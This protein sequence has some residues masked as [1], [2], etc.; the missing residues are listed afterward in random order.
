MNITKALPSRYAYSNQKTETISSQQTVQADTFRSTQGMEKPP[1]RA[2]LKAFFEPKPEPPK[3]SPGELKMSR[4]PDIPSPARSSFGVAEMGTKVYI[5]GGHQGQE[6]TY[7][8]ESFMDQFLVFDKESKTWFELAPRPVKA[9]GYDIVADGQYVYAFGGFTYSGEHNPKWKSIPDVHRYDTRTNEWEKV[10]ELENPR[11]SN[12]V[13]QIGRKAYLV[14]GWNSTPKSDNDAEGEFLKSVEVMDLDTGE[15]STAPY[16]IPSPTRRA[17]TALEQ[18]GKIVMLG[19]LGEGS[20]HF[21]MLDN[22]TI[23][24]PETGEVEEAPKLPFPTFAPGA[25]KIGDTLFL[26][27]GL[28]KE[29]EDG[30]RYVDSVY[31]LEPGSDKWEDAKVYLAENKGFPM[32]V[33]LEENQL[34]I[35]GGHSYDDGDAPVSTFEVLTREKPESDS[36]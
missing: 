24:D 14:G 19:G 15:I 9:H 26:F 12:G 28:I 33:N 13:V 22:V 1:T 18:D 34:G 32:V 35:L 4:L 21:E 36:E 31:K 30:Y 2:D 8:P 11:S 23:I 5:C 16:E 27:G 7:P 10:G 20:T 17:F 6:H 29:G 25:G 3:D